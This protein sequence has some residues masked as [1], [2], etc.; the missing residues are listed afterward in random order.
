MA[1][2]LAD[3]DRVARVLAAHGAAV[4]IAAVN[5][6]DS[7]VI[8]GDGPAVLAVLAALEAEGVPSRPLVVSHAFH[9][10]LM[11]P[12]L[13][14][15][16]RVAASITYKAPQIRLVSNVTGQVSSREAMKDGSYWRRHLRGTVLF[17]AGVQELHR[18]GV[19]LFLELGP[20]GVLSALGPRTVRE[21]TFVPTLRDGRDEWAGT[22]QALGRLY[23]LGVRVDWAGVDRE[24]SRRRVTLPT[25][26]FERSRHWVQAA[27]TQRRSAE[28]P[29]SG[30]G[31]EQST[32]HPLLHRHLPSPLDSQQ[33][34]SQLDAG[35]LPLIRDHRVHGVSILPATAFIELALAAGARVIGGTPAVD[36]FEIHEPLPFRGDDERTDAGG[37]DQRRPGCVARAD[38]QPRRQRW[39]PG[40]VDAARRRSGQRRRRGERCVVRPGRAD[41]PLHRAD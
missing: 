11:D 22:L 33:F 3:A 34:E 2:V 30:R 37:A 14:E 26:P 35:T 38:L 17:A 1:A 10:P 13:A 36:E 20:G 21:A 6:P 28:R 40:V 16:E 27:T 15:F 39:R 19:G 32:G 12:I 9:S 24:Y 4:S 7:T 41:G 29:A 23:C 5:A 31:A 18:Q 8:S 25:T